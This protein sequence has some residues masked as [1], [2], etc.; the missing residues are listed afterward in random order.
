MGQEVVK[1]RLLLVGTKKDLTGGNYVWLSEVESKAT[2]PGYGFA[3]TSSATQEGIEALKELMAE[4]TLAI[5]T[6]PRFGPMSTDMAAQAGQEPGCCSHD[7]YSA[8]LSS[9]S[10]RSVMNGNECRRCIP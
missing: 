7:V 5:P 10:Q 2:Q 6:F 3:E 8:L 1:A 9:S 4:A